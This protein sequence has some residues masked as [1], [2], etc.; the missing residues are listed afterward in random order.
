MLVVNDP[1]QHYLIDHHRTG[2]MPGGYAMLARRPVL[3]K[4]MGL[5]NIF[6]RLIG[7][8]AAEFLLRFC[9]YCENDWIFS[10]IS[11]P[12]QRDLRYATTGVSGL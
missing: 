12:I 2:A 10:V 3:Q 5:Q 6:G 8:E 4:F 11:S 7:A 9:R 1:L